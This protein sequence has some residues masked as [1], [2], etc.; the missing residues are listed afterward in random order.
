MSSQI[1]AFTHAP[2]KK[3]D[4]FLASLV[5]NK[6]YPNQDMI[7]KVDVE[8]DE[9]YSVAIDANFSSRV[10]AASDSF[11]KTALTRLFSVTGDASDNTVCDIVADKALT[12][13]LRQP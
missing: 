13:E 8:E 11:F 6:H 9:G 4:V 1:F 12:Y 10:E 3:D 7:A 2:Y 5:P